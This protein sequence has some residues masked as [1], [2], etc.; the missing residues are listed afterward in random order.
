MRPGKQQRPEP[1]LAVYRYDPDDEEERHRD[2]YV[3][4][5][6]V[7]IAVEILS[8][9]PEDR[10]RTTRPMKYARAGI[11]R[12]W[13]VEHENGDAA[14]HVYE[15]AD[16]KERRYV[17]VTVPRKR[18]QLQQPFAIDLDVTSLATHPAQRRR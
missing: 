16:T 8:E 18:L 4:S 10:D 1:D 12:F 5:E 6:E 17:P 13:R 15:L 2:T 3:L 7:L 14:I 9:E 11:P